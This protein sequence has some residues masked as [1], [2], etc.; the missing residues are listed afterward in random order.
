MRQYQNQVDDF[1]VDGLKVFIVHDTDPLNPRKEWDHAGTMV[2]FHKRYELGDKH[3]FP[4]PQAFRLWWEQY[5][6][7]GTLLPLY[8][9]DHKIGRAHV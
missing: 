4:T 7:G 9:Y 5:G 2:C 3:D 8:L 1:N 6:T